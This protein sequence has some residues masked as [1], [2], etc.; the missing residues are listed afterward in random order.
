MTQGWLR[1]EGLVLCLLVLACVVP[2]AT[3]QVTVTAG[4]STDEAWY[5]EGN[6]WI[7]QK[8]YDLAIQAYDQAL[9]LNPGHAR[10]HFARG[11]ALASL[12]MHKD[13]LAAYD[14]AILRDP[15][16]AGAVASY[17][18]TSERVLYPEI[19]SGSLIKGCWVSGWRWL[20]L[21]NRQGVTDVVVALSP[22]N[23]QGVT[24][25]VYVKK[26]YSHLFEGVVPPGGYDFYITYG[27]R[28]NPA[29]NRFDRNAGYLK[30][31]IPYYFDGAQ[32]GGYAMTFI[33]QAPHA[34]WYTYSLV[35]IEETGFPLL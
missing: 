5:R 22:R 21:D 19:L 9:A 1:W 32:G 6:N 31:D 27:E 14:A 35:P 11:Q 20:E 33:A 28:W 26:G 17:L 2:L 16:L 24:A 12:G 15:G 30:W 29:E 8:R 4:P 3:A 34:N 23:S 10:S 18:Q 25:A 13:A 7:N